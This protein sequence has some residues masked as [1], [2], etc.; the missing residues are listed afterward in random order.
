ME[1]LAGTNEVAKFTAKLL[2][3]EEEIVA[4]DEKIEKTESELAAA[5][6]DFKTFL[7]TVKF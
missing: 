3:L 2:K 5:E 6:N 1:A 4:M 7:K